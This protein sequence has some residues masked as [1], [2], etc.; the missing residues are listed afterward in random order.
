L[1]EKRNVPSTIKVSGYKMVGRPRKSFDGSQER[2]I[3]PSNVLFFLDGKIVRLLSFNR[4]MDVCYLYNLYNQKEQTM[5]YSDFKKHRKRAYTVINTARLLGRSRMQLYRY[6]RDGLIEPPVGILPGGER[7]FRKK[8][9][10]SE[11]D[12]FKIREAMASLHHGRPRK[13]G[14][15]TN[16]RTLTEKELR[17]K[18]GDALVLYTRTKDG[19]FIP[20]WSEETY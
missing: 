11:D 6:Y 8:S 17:A 18:M 16:N 12:V 10:Y 13:D 14:R 9:Y 19:D 1:R 20:V 2:E 7:V 4:A 3:K 5:L 15:T